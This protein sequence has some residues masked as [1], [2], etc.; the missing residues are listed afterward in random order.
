MCKEDVRLGRAASGR[1]VTIV[2]VLDVATRIMTANAGRLGLSLYM[3]GT[4]TGPLTASAVVGTLDN[5]Q[6][7]PLLGVSGVTPFDRVDIDRGGILLTGD[8]YYL[9]RGTA[10]PTIIVGE[11]YLTDELRNI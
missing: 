5:G 3:D 1:A 2:T 9:A 8:I 6:F 10:A 11:T 7:V 4:A